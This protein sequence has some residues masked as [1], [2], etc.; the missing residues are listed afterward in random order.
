MKKSTEAVRLTE[1]DRGHLEE[2]NPYDCRYRI[3]L[4]ET[5]D[6]IVLGDYGSNFNA[7]THDL[8][9]KITTQSNTLPIE[10]LTPS[11][12]LQT[13]INGTAYLPI[14]FTASISMKESITIINSGSNIPISIPGL[15][16]IVVN[17]EM[18][19][20]LL[21][22][23]F[24]KAICFDLHYHLEGVKGIVK[25]KNICELESAVDRNLICSANRLKNK[26]NKR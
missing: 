1:P 24:F 6:S 10:G 20:L 11:I 17:Q 25:G 13:A 23:P 16:F 26:Q 19:T 21:G 14:E 5:I 4:D 7:I 18:D 8:L 12:Q 22:R 15:N 9:T 3:L 2:P